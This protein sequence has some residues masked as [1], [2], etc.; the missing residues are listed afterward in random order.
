MRKQLHSSSDSPRKQKSEISILSILL[1]SLFLGLIIGAGVGKSYIL[2]VAL[3][4]AVIL[5]ANR[6]KIAAQET[7]AKGHDGSQK[8]ANSENEYY[9]WPELGQFAFA[10]AISAQSYQDA[11]KQLAQENAINP[12]EDS[13]FK[14]HILKVHLVVD[15]SNPFDDI[16]RIDINNCTI[17]Y[18]NSDQVRSFH[19]RLDEKG[20]ANQ[21]TTC[22]AIITK[23]EEVN[24]KTVSYSARLDIEPL[25][26]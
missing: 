25:E 13:D 9:A 19:R 24:G 17:G 11:I 6:G 16:V 23:N 22:N 2:P 3:I 26:C 10:V 7:A 4:A 5:Y 20:L 14:A 8:N 21:T 18:L 1:L 15:N 12:N